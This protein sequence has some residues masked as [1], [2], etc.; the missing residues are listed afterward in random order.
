MKKKLQDRHFLKDG[1]VELE[2]IKNEVQC[3]KSYF[4]GNTGWL[5]DM[6]VVE[7]SGLNRTFFFLLNWF[8]TLS[9]PTVNI[10]KHM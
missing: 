10:E 7:S 4:G 9:R 2:N 6:L 1:N 8:N 5:R 3:I